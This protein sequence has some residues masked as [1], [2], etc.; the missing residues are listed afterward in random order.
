MQAEQQTEEAPQPREEPRGLLPE[1][2]QRKQ[3]LLAKQAKKAQRH[4]K[5]TKAEDKELEALL[6][7]ERLEQERQAA[8]HRL[9]STADT[10]GRKE[11]GRIKREVTDQVKELHA[12]EQATTAGIMKIYRKGMAELDKETK[13]AMQRIQEQHNKMLQAIKNERDKDERAVREGYRKQ[14]EELE[15]QMDAD[16]NQVSDLVASF[17]LDIKDLELEQLQELLRSGI[18]Q[19]GGGKERDYL[20]VPGTEK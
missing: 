19:I 4:E 15:S 7:I 8:I 12:D 5:L 3:E 10:Y 2:E 18:V 20:V 17:I 9:S 1:E 6:T 13:A 14:Y 11:I 16:T